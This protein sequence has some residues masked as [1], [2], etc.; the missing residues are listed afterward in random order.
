MK[1]HRHR[2]S[3]L[4]AARRGRRRLRRLD[5]RPRLRARPVAPTPD[6]RPARPSPDLHPGARPRRR[7]TPRA[8]PRRT[9]RRARRRAADARPPAPAE[10][11]I[12]RAY[13]VLGG[14]PGI[15]GLV[16]VLREVPETTARRAGRDERAPR[17]PDGR[18][19]RATGRSARAIPD[20]TQPARHHDQERHRDR[21][22]L[23]R[24][25]LGRRHASM[26]YRLAQVVYTLTQFST[27]KSVVFQIEG[28]TVTVFGGEGIVLDG[29]VGRADYDD[30]LPSIFV[31]R[32]AYGAALGNPGRV[33]GNANV[34]EA[35]FRVALLD[36]SGADA[37]RRARSWRP[38]APAA[39]APST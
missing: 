19:D 27:V 32:P 26:Q 6:D 5:R 1:R 35:T 31:D 11:T 28:E 34:F 30:Q 29:P 18:R 21:R 9:D 22:S 15:E 16:P 13:F 20:G 14:E 37:R 24:V 39:G 12:V 23:D 2:S 4:G 8:R 38:A 3:S 17:R 36:A 10:T 7:P 33:A 25:R